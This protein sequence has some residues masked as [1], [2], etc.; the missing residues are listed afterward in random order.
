M[1][2][3]WL[4][5]RDRARTG[6]VRDRRWGLVAGGH[7]GEVVPLDI[8]PFFRTKKSLIG[9]GAF[10]REEVAKCFELA[11]RGLI[12]PLVYKAFPLEEARKA[13]ETLERRESFGKVVL[14]P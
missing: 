11:S 6:R 1:S 2:R 9:S 4:T 14:L 13:V 12:R 10:T 7:G 5:G 3:C 8:I